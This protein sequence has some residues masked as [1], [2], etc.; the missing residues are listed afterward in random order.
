MYSSKSPLG[1]LELLVVSADF[2]DGIVE[3][4]EEGL[5]VLSAE[6]VSE[7]VIDQGAEAS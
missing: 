5:L 6:F 7:D 2:F 1:V 4:G 3:E